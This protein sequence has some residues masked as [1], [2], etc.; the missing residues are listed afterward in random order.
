MFP[1][2]PRA[3]TLST[4]DAIV[5][6]LDPGCPRVLSPRTRGV[7]VTEG[8]AGPDDLSV[9]LYVSFEYNSEG[10]KP[11]GR[12]ILDRLGTALTDGRLK[13]FSFVIEGH[14]D[15]VGSDQFNLRLSQ[16][17]AEAVRQYLLN[18]FAI[19][20]SRLTARGLGKTQLL[21]PTHPE[22]AVN[23]RVRVV[24]T[25]AGMPLA[26]DAD[27]SQRVQGSAPVVKPFARGLDDCSESS[28]DGTAAC[29]RVIE[30]GKLKGNALASAYYNRALARL[31]M[32]QYDRAIADFDES[33]RLDPTSAWTFLNRGNAWYGKGDLDRALADFDQAIR[34]DPKYALPYNN[35]AE[36]HKDR[37]DLHQAI[38]DYGRAIDLDRGYTA[39]YVGRGLA[40]EGLGEAAR[41]REDFNSALS[42]PARR[43]ADQE[44]QNTARRHLAALA[45]PIRRIALVIGNSN[46]AAA[47]TL[48]ARMDSEV[49]ARLLRTAAFDSVTLVGDLNRERFIDALTA[50]GREAQTA[51]WAVIYFAGHGIEIDGLNYLISVDAR[52]EDGRAAQFET[53]SLERVLRAVGGAHK[54]GLVMLD[55]CRDN[56]FAARL[57]SL[58][59]R[60]I[61]PGLAQSDPAPGTL[62]VYAAKHGQVALD[63][64]SG[65]SAFVS[66]LAK[67]VVTPGL[68]INDLFRRV[69]DDV[70]KM[71]NGQQEP[72]TYGSLS[73]AEQYYFM[74]R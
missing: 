51:D 32:G 40:Y 55:A 27:A 68:E 4:T 70:M 36:V 52:F 44:E 10:L 1:I 46:Y 21:D 67:Q 9:N 66:A 18:K 58:T 60:S 6:D 15:G 31:E 65:N 2:V 56:P 49:V 34:L 22:D 37:G 16:R 30:S 17:R 23:R 48:N 45:V 64:D 42:L 69:R 57:R 61:G 53:I 3:Q 73:G 13:K 14:T 8:T 47:P 71:T 41:A 74:S 29:D 7:T 59:T 20:G 19:E 50:F 12:Q 35:R 25:T 63:P 38:D 62:V 43:A 24:N 26:P 72:Y 33:I 28:R 11:E 39:A 54:L 5:C